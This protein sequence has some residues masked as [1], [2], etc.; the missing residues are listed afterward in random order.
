MGDL[1][2]REHVF[3]LTSGMLKQ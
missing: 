1:L 3:S 2:F